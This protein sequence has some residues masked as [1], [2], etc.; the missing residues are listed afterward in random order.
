VFISKIGLYL[1]SSQIAPEHPMARPNT[2]LPQGRN[3]LFEKQD[4]RSPGNSP[5]SHAGC[6][7]YS[8]NKERKQEFSA[9]KMPIFE[10]VLL[11]LPLQYLSP[12]YALTVS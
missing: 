12:F 9:P 11:L 4:C 7:F 6:L 1:C 5:R 3:R 8:T 2:L 10:L